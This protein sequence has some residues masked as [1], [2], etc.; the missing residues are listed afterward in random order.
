MQEGIGYVRVDSPIGWY[1]LLPP[2]V[3]GGVICRANDGGVVWLH[4]DF[5][6]NHSAR[7][8]A[9]TSADAEVGKFPLAVWSTAIS[10]TA[11]TENVALILIVC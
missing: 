11:K 7:T 1:R 5:T 6:Q 4:L 10:P 3:R 9:S 2:L 8:D